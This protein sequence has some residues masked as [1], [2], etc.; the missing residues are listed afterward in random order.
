MSVRHKSELVH[1][2]RAERALGHPLPA[3]AMVHHAD[4]SKRVD[5]PLVICQDAAYHGLLHARMRVKAAGGN[6]NTDKLCSRCRQPKPFDQFSHTNQ[7]R[8]YLGRVA[9]C[10]PCDADLHR[11]RY[12]RH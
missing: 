10:R 5:A 12:A 11:A 7:R 8:A 6:P 9:Y 3:T 4:G 2:Q 1:R